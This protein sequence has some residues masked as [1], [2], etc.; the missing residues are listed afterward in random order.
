[1][2]LSLPARPGLRQKIQFYDILAAARAQHRG[3]PEIIILAGEVDVCR[4]KPIR[5]VLDPDIVKQLRLVPWQ[6]IGRAS[7]Q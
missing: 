7:R 2:L 3:A 6:Q 4:D 5:N 1:V